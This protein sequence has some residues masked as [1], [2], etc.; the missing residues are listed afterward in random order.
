MTLDAWSQGMEDRRVQILAEGRT[1]RLFA[2]FDGLSDQALLDVE[3][4]ALA[5][6][7]YMP[8]GLLDDLRTEIAYRGVVR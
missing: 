1:P 5:D 4:C 2:E 3:R 7:D 8:A 6:P